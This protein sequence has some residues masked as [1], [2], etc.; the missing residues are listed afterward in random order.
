MASDPPLAIAT[1]YAFRD[2]PCEGCKGG[3]G[4]SGLFV[5]AQPP[6]SIQGSDGGVGRAAGAEQRRAKESA[7]KFGGKTNSVRS[8]AVA[9][10]QLSR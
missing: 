7:P 9:V 5:S 3:V 2:Q 8:K 4:E 10:C 1:G 6:L